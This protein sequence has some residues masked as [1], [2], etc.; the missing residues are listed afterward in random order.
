MK[1]PFFGKKKE[2]SG[3][4]LKELNDDPFNDES[5]KQ[6]KNPMEEDPFK[7]S[8]GD[9]YD[10]FGNKKIPERAGTSDFSMQREQ[11]EPYK[12]DDK[13]EL[14]IAKLDA[15]KAEVNNISH[16]LENLE[17]KQKNKLY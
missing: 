12:N 11:Q 14:I 2:D 10:S 5:T 17:R 13:Q 9:E 15:I 1:L 3:L 4:D 16:R 6:E 7:K 8:L